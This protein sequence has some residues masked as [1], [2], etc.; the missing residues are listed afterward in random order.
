MLYLLKHI[1]FLFVALLFFLIS[2]NTVQE[3]QGI[4]SVIV[5]VPEGISLSEKDFLNVSY[6]PFSEKKGNTMVIVP[7][8]YSPFVEVTAYSGAEIINKR[9]P[10]KLEVL[11]RIMDNNEV[12][13]VIFVEVN[14]EGKENLLR[15]FSEKV[16]VLLDSGN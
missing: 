16:R 8:S 14:G 4:S 15:L 2:C 3:V 12:I 10:G 9:N 5:Q 11:I 1:K 7:Y 6:V 13:R